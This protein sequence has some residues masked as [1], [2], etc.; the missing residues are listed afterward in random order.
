MSTENRQSQI[1]NF[2]VEHHG[3]S[4]NTGFTNHSPHRPAAMAS[5]IRQAVEYSLD[6]WS[7][8]NTRMP[9]GFQELWQ[10]DF[11]NSM[12]SGTYDH[13]HVRFWCYCHLYTTVIRRAN[14]I[15]KLI[16]ESFPHE[17]FALLR[18][19]MESFAVCH[20]ISERLKCRPTV[21]HD[22]IAYVFLLTVYRM[23]H[24]DS[25]LRCEYNMK[26]HYPA[27]QYEPIAEEL[28][29]RFK[30]FPHP[31]AW[32]DPCSKK[33]QRT[34][35][36]IE[37]ADKKYRILYNL[38]NS[39]VHGNIGTGYPLLDIG[40]PLRAVPIVPTGKNHFF[41]WISDL[42]FDFLTA[43]IVVRT[44]QLYPEFL[45]SLE[46]FARKADDLIAVGKE[47]LEKLSWRI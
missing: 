36:L 29:A 5:L 7:E 30:A 12:L 38:G 35:D 34:A 45:G 24:T 26:P 3:A 46:G 33:A 6:L 13:D 4:V 10:P 16:E 32:I 2:A 37:A 31:L 20:H 14:A 1:S 15:A 18:S 17:A 43:E 9:P 23:K 19:V 40:T 47:V 11:A 25:R 28:K 21:C 42:E 39:E 41:K 44:T 8:L 27:E 22:Y